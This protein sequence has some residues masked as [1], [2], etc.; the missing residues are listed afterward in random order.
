MS[1]ATGREIFSRPS[2]PLFQCR[3]V[4]HGD[5]SGDNL[6]AALALASAGIKIFPAGADKRPLL[7]GWQDAA[8]SDADQIN[9]WW[10]HAAA[11]PAIPCGQNDLLVI[12]CDR[13]DGGADG[14][15]AFKS[16]VAAHG[17]LPRQV[18]LVKTPNGGLHVYFR[19][20][21]GEAL[22]NGRGSLPPGIDVRGAG[23][24]VVGPGARLPDGRGWTAVA[25]RSPDQGRA[26]TA[27][28]ARRHAAPAAARGSPRAE[29]HRDQ[30]RSRPRLCD[31]GTQWG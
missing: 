4:R 24:F 26:A 18:P 8:T 13:H 5:A 17:G 19:Q 7:K 12:D 28:L 31:G 15:A 27:A 6:S 29:Q 1:R 22:G 30:R 20:P 3:S 16:L 11:L 21:N 10:D 2:L 9:T 14:V 23:G 25:G